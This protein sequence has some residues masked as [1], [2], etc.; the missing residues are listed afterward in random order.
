MMHTERF[1][2]QRAFFDGI[3]DRWDTWEDLER[4]DARLSAGLEAFGLGPDETVIDIGS[5]TGNLSRALVRRLSPRGRVVAIDLS[6]AM[7]AR[8]SAKVPDERIAW[9]VGTAD[10]L[11]MGVASAD[12]AVLFSVWPH[13]EPRGDVVAELAR[14]LRPGRPVHVWHLASRERINAIHAAAGEAVRD[15]LLPPAAETAGLFE[16]AGF[17]VTGIVDDDERYLVTAL[18]PVGT[19]P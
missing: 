16:A 12:R 15:H 4:L 10:H 5:G 2:T 6:P 1:D 18:S 19:L 17:R 7:I 11:P 14:V 9:H 3:A 8:A 13:L